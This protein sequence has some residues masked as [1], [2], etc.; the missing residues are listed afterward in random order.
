MKSSFKIDL[1]TT[2]LIILIIIAI[3]YLL[4]YKNITIESFTTYSYDP[5]N[6]MDTGATPLTYYNYPAYRKPYMYPYRFY[7]SYPYPYMKHYEM[8]I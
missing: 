3:C 2:L 1:Q 8:N 7:S 4:F 6:Y 5:F